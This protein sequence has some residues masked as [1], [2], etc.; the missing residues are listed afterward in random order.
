ML[1]ES[2]D[3]FEV[4]V[5]DEAAV[6]VEKSEPMVV[7]ETVVVGAGEVAEGAVAGA[8]AIFCA[9]TIVVV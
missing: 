8:P 6:V 3:V 4:T 9:T 1:V 2:L 7:T 5:V